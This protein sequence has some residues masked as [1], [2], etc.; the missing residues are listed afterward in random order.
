M[1]CKIRR[2]VV[3]QNLFASRNELSS[4]D[5]CLFCPSLEDAL[6]FYYKKQEIKKEIN[7]QMIK[8]REREERIREKKSIPALKLRE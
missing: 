7:I 8:N 5:D 6:S 4:S 1:K 3:N 2:G